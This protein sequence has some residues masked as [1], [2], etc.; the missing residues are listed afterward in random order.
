MLPSKEPP[1]FCWLSHPLQITDGAKF[2]AEIIVEQL[3]MLELAL[4]STYLILPKSKAGGLAHL[5]LPGGKHPASG[6]TGQGPARRKP[7]PTSSTLGGADFFPLTKPPP[8]VL[9]S[10]EANC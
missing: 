4:G 8:Q 9:R 10:V 5:M 7:V 2:K 3:V 1:F 6:L